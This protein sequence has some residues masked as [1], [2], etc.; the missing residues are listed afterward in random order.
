[1]A[2]WWVSQNQTWQHER[3]GGYLWAP[4]KDAAGRTPHHWA[5]MNQVQ[6]GD[7]IFSFVDQKIAA[8]SVAKGPA[9][10]SVRPGEFSDRSLWEQ[11]GK[12]IDVVY[13]DVKPPLPIAPLRASLMNAL[14]STYS[15]LN[16]SGTGNQGYLFGIPGRAGRLILDTLGGT[17]VVQT[18][19]VESIVSSTER[20]TTVKSRVGQGKFRSD[21]LSLWNGRCCITGLNIPDLLRASHIKPWTDSNDRERL[22]VFNGLL[23]SPAYDA[24]FDQGY[25]SFA[26]DGPI[27]ISPRIADSQLIQLGIMKIARVDGLCSEHLGYL[28]HHRREVFHIT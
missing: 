11:Q 8:I 17:D 4:N 26:D 19:V 1:M 10:N 23:L 28:A 5:T 22:H 14:P 7:I 2:Y 16:S 3:R 18:A 9:Q 13:K 6:A 21:L 25:I 27:M 15:P 20:D 12:R 24:A